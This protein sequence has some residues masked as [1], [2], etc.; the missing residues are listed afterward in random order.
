M[1]KINQKENKSKIS[2]DSLKIRIPIEKVKILDE[3]IRGNQIL[4]NELSGEILKEFKT[5]SKRID[6][7]THSTYFGIEVQM[8]S[9]QQTKEFLV[10]LLNAKILKEQY[11]DGLTVLNIR[12]VY[13]ELQSYKIAQFSFKDFL[14]SECT[15][16]DFKRDLYG[17][18]SS[19]ASKFTKELEQFTKPSP[20]RKY[21]CNRINE[22]HNK[23]I[24][25]SKR[26]TATPSNPF[27]K[28]Y[29]K[30]LE[31]VNNSK[32]FYNAYLR[33]HDVSQVLRQETSVKNKKH[34]RSLGIENTTLLN[35]LCLS[36]T[37]LE[38]IFSRS[39]Y[40]HLEKRTRTMSE[41]KELKTMEQ[42]MLNSLQMIMDKDVSYK[43]ARHN[44]TSNIAA[45][46]T[47]TS[48]QKT[49]DK[50]YEKYIRGND[51]DKTT[52]DIDLLFELIGME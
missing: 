49:L 26:E 40:Y 14:N 28:F 15:D 18:T 45:R 17:V 23:G 29:H 51:I 2:I 37:T 1:P 34:F 24:E 27:L 36:D 47:R 3:T 30:G 16:V 50:L 20:K 35:L 7:V 43:I 19:M 42:F 11:F 8:T 13:D 21:G 39:I 46:T 10:I 52:K 22:Q 38:H 9:T 48:Y 25:W 41:Q 12:P 44:L 6:H 31:M 4:I 33:Q 32:N 5:K